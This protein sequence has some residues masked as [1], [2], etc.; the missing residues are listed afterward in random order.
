MANKKDSPKA[1]QEKYDKVEAAW[2]DLAPGETFGGMTLAQF[3]ARIAPSKDEREVLDQLDNQMK[4]HITGRDGA[5]IVS[6]NGVELVVNGVIGNPDFGPDSAHP[7]AM[8]YI[9][10]SDRKSGLTRKT[11]PTP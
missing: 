8:G 9:R 3:Q 2:K 1:N 4:E 7:E 11:T 10:K 5:D 6:M